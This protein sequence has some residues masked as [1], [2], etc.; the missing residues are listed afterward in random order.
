MARLEPHCIFLNP[1]PALFQKERSDFP[2]PEPLFGEKFM[3]SKELVYSYAK[4]VI[5]TSIH[6]LQIYLGNELVENFEYRIPIEK[7][8]EQFNQSNRCPGTF[9]P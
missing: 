2:S 3:V 4:A 9:Y 7:S 5:V 8:D 1:L 6:T